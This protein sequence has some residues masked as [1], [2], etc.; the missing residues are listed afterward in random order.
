MLDT[1]LPL[2]LDVS[3]A[4]NKMPPYVIK[5]VDPTGSTRP[6]NPNSNKSLK[7]DEFRRFHS[8]KVSGA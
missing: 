6:A 8:K 1:I 3:S 2:A 4:M 5:L 7:F